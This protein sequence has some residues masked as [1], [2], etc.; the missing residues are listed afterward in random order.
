MHDKRVMRKR[1]L[2][3]GGIVVAQDEETR[4][5]NTC[6][7]YCVHDD[8]L[9]VEHPATPHTY[10]ESHALPPRGILHR[11]RDVTPEKVVKQELCRHSLPV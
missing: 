9:L 2:G 6:P 8:L 1:L 4:L 10:R 5:S 11:I 3:S 7:S